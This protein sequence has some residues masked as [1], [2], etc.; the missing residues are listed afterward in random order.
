[1][2]DLSIVL[3]N[4][5]GAL[6]EMGEALGRAGVSIEG[7]GACGGWWTMLNGR[8]KYQQYGQKKAESLIFNCLA[9]N[10]LITSILGP[11]ESNA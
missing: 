1:M 2:K 6:A 9:L 7:G 10:Y 5:P 11:I 3:E 8:A 4:R